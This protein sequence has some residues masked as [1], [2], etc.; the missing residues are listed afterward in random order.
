MPNCSPSEGR[1]IA[2]KEALRDTKSQEIPEPITPELLLHGYNLPSFNLIPSL[3]SADDPETAKYANFDPTTQIT[4]N[5]DKLCKVRTKLF[6][7]F[8]TEFIPQLIYQATN[9]NSRF[10]PIK[11]KKLKI[12]DLVLIKED[13]FKR[14]NL[15]MGRVL[16]INTNNLLEVTGAVVR[17][18]STGEKVKR[19]VNALIP[20]LT[21]EDD[22]SLGTPAV[23]EQAGSGQAPRSTTKCTKQARNRRL[24]AVACEQKMQTILAE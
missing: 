4:T 19:H 9:K 21:R 16:E 6:D 13:N 15:P 3:Q 1:P 10:K 22:P 24:A 23:M 18:G 2:F 20:L 17:K 11:H 8:N 12:G 7:L 14:S 5:H